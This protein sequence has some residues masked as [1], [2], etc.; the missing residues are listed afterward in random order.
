ML[1]LIIAAP[2]L[3]AGTTPDY[4]TQRSQFLAAEKAF[5]QG[6][7]KR[8]KQLKSQLVHYPLYPYLEYRE[9]KKQ[10][11][12]QTSPQVE[13]FLSLYEKTPIASRLRRAWLKELAKRKAWGPYLLSLRPGMGTVY[14]C[15]HIQALLKT[16]HTDE[17]MQKIQPVWLN[18]KSQPDACDPV[19]SAWEKAGGLTGELAWE[20]IELAMKASNRGL[21]RYLK[22]Y[23]PVTEQK[24]LEL[25][26]RVNRKPEMILNQQAFNDPHPFREKILLH[27]FKRLVRRDLDAAIAAWPG[28]NSSYPFSDLQRYQAERS[29][30]LSLV[31]S[32][33]PDA[34]DKLNNFHPN[35]QDDHLLE[36]RIRA[37]LSRQEWDKTINWINSLPESLKIRDR[38]RYWLAMALAE[39][40]KQTLANDIL[41]GLANERSYYGFL[42]ADQL[43]K[44]YR[45]A[46]TPLEFDQEKL[47]QL[48]L[49]S[50]IQRAHEL[51]IL[52]RFIDA[53]R[54][55][56]QA[57]R[58]M[59]TEELQLVSKLAQKWGWHD[60]AI[61]TLART[62]YWD[63]LKLRFPLEHKKKILNNS[64]KQ[65]LDNAWVFAVIRQESA[66]STDAESPAGARGLM[67]LMPRTARFI[68]K[69][70]NFRR[71][72]KRDLFNP[73]INIKLGTAYLSRIL[74][75]LGNN[76]V[77]ATAAYNAGPHRVRKWLPE[78]STPADIWVEAIPF[79]ETRRYTQRV[80]SYSVIY[81]Q[82]LG[83]KVKRLSQRMPQ[84]NP[85]TE[86]AQISSPSAGNVAL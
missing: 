76:Q 1:Q 81:D 60:Q 30:M 62:G 32:D 25:W 65:Q 21:A 84:I 7:R 9:L 51:F 4:S 26:L 13:A 36:S 57:T 28:L 68:A 5:S 45:F 41:G 73:D 23:L 40:G 11:S 24:H 8:Y 78:G 17:A 33:R 42:A 44:E 22:R 47:D 19:F 20:R 34:I 80:L 31:R 58:D 35:E 16:G 50:G 85:V 61:F 12:T 52:E 69:K 79:R 48:T 70:A 3:T 27:G 74:N 56:R 54:E 83:N 39:T 55:W 53:R 63:D 37:A 86:T 71:P 2:T 15:N 82:M 38:W 43:N 59:E 72:K 29:L 64:N 10:L 77:L 6:D 18:G 75:Q 14:E 46:P 49:H 67:Q 66:F